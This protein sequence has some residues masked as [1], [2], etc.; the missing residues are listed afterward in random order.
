MAVRVGGKKGGREGEVKG[1]AGRIELGH[2][3]PHTSIKYNLRKREVSKQ[4]EEREV[5]RNQPKRK[6]DNHKKKQINEK[7]I[8]WHT[9]RI[10][11]TAR[12]CNFSW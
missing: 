7:K 1:K 2:A 3:T 10:K 9:L 5:E 4:I 11:T 8:A 6:K 12:M